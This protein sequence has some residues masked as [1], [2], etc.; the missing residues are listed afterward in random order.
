MNLV[1]LL[2]QPLLFRKKVVNLKKIADLKLKSAVNVFF[3]VCNFVVE[4]VM[5]K[6]AIW[7]LP[8]RA[9]LTHKDPGSYRQTDSDFFFD[10]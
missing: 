6:I 8:R 9:L 7:K 10:K 4:L 5:M 2:H 3:N 1:F